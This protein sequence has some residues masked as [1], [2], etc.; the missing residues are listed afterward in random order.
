MS[1]TNEPGSNTRMAKAVV[2]GLLAA[3]QFFIAV[4]FFVEWVAPYMGWQP[5]LGDVF[6]SPVVPIALA[7]ICGFIGT[8]LFISANK[9]LKESKPPRS[10]QRH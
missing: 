9:A 1:P 8:M 2:M 6:I 5:I 4:L 10:K 7:L 3:I